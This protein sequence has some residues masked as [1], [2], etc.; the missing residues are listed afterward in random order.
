MKITLSAAILAATM[1]LATSAVQAQQSNFYAGVGLGQSR[2]TN[3]SESE[4][5]DYL[6][7]QGFSNP[8]THVDRKDNAYRLMGGFQFTPNI[9]VEAFYTDLGKF[10]AAS[11]VTAPNINGTGSVSSTYKVNGFGADLVVSSAFSPQLSVFGRI[12][13]FQS[14]TEANFSASGLVALQ[15]THGSRNRTGD[16][17]GLGLQ[18]DLTKNVGLRLEAERFRKLGDNSTGGDID[19]DMYSVGTVFRF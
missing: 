18:Y 1:A 2:A 5:N 3:L 4:A 13:V 7:S 19:V 6:R 11:T 15:F 8:S 9:A 16:H 12:G 17:L 10:N 14:K